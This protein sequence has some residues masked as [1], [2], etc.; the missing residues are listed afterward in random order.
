MIS[1]TGQSVPAAESSRLVAPLSRCG[2][3]DGHVCLATIIPIAPSVPVVDSFFLHLPSAFS[4]ERYILPIHAV[5]RIPHAHD[6][7][8]DHAGSRAL[9]AAFL[10]EMSRFT[11]RMSG[12]K[13]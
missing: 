12:W 10:F 11:S 1:L 5:F 9:R 13:A 2:S 3:P 6:L 4:F 7:A 8:V